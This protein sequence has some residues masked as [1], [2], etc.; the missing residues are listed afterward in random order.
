MTRHPSLGRSFR[1]KMAANTELL[2]ISGRL[3]RPLTALL[4]I[5]AVALPCLV[6][7]HAA[8]PDG[9]LPATVGKASGGGDPLGKIDEFLANGTDDSVS[10]DVRLERVLQEAAMENKTVILT[11]LNEAWAV[12]GSIFDL[13][14][15]S[16]RIG[17]GTR[18]LLDHLVVVALDKKAYARCVSVHSHCFALTTEGVD[19]TGEKFFMTP[20]YLKMM[21]RR[22]D[23]LR[24]VLEKGYSFI[25]TDADIMWFRDPFPRFH[26]DADFQIACDRFLGNSFDLNNMPNGGFNYVKSSNRTIEFYKFW[27]SSREAYP[28]KHDQD[29]LNYIKF[30]PF[31][32]EIGLKMRF[33]DTAFFGGFCEPS[34]D[35]NHL[36]HLGGYR[37][38]AVC[39]HPIIRICSQT[40]NSWWKNDDACI[41]LCIRGPVKPFVKIKNFPLVK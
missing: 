15:E 31:L 41:Q 2:P 23:F 26:T 17:I 32:S 14:L 27:Y 39:L 4:L 37:K 19:F 38:I 28:G 16:F 12:T 1:F 21:W 40:Y 6:F 24:I 3:G 36:N 5:S 9:P 29:V 18:R 35:L 30:Y 10:E 25:F 7:Y 33:L 8:R 20:D 34:R 11:T 13:F 22:I